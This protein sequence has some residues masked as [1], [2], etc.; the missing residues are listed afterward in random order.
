VLPHPFFGCEWQPFAADAAENK[1][2]ARDFLQAYG[3]SRVSERLFQ[4]DT[5]IA[6]NP[7]RPA[8]GGFGVNV[9][10]NIFTIVRSGV[11]FF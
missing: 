1:G 7:Q 11:R 6:P 3:K 4:A 2:S 5:E 9:F 10:L 8:A